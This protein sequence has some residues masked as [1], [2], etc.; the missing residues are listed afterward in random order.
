MMQLA[1]NV[2]IERHGKR[3]SYRR[4]P[5]AQK[6][7]IVAETYEP[8]MSVSIVARRHDVNAN[9]VFR[10]RQLFGTDGGDKKAVAEFIPLGIVGPSPEAKRQTSGMI[11]IVLGNKMCVTVDG[12]VDEGALSRVLTVIRGLP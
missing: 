3:G 7:Q 4:W 8:G 9:Q 1:Q 12:D 6:R 10:W 11:T 2:A 5:E